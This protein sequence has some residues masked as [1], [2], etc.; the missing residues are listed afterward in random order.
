MIRNWTRQSG[1]R[2]LK[3]TASRKCGRRG[4]VWALA[5]F[6]TL[7]SAAGAPQGT[8]RK[9]P[10]A[11]LSSAQQAEGAKISEAAMNAMRSGDYSGAAAGFEKLTQI[12]PGVA[13]FHAN[14]GMATYWAGRPRD[15]IAPCRKALKLK[16]SLASARYF[17][18]LSLAEAGEC[19]EAFPYLESDLKRAP[20]L[21]LKRLMGLDATRCAMALGQPGKAVDFILGL[22]RDFPDDP[23]VLFLGTHLFSDL[24]TRASERLLRMAPGSYQAH[25]MNAEVSALQGKTEDAIA[26]Y[27]KVLALN[28]HMAGIHYEIGRLLLS[29][30]PAQL[31]AA[32][33]EFEEELRLDPA[34]A[35]SEY[36]LGEMARQARSWEEAIRHFD[37]AVRLQPAF[38]AALVGLGKSLVSAGRAAE[39]VAPLE[40]AVKLA[41]DDPVAHYQLSFAYRR[42]GREA[43]ANREIAFYRQAHDKQMRAL[44]NIRTGILGNLVQP[45]TAEPPQ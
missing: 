29:S 34:D 16:P 26:E 42:V 3:L 33:G 37:R 4:T 21:Q 13:E 2:K 35:A 12:A 31:D 18:A 39:A 43:D 36:E 11:S 9:T 24:S 5:T 23:E 25:Q 28:P 30:D 22:D 1:E 20:D 38:T 6:L 17:L 44:Q 40:T 8:E 32:R 10:G 7:S 41:P 45:Q 27:R 14:L 19:Q 15:A